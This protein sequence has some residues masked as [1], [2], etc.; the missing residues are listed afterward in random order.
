MM[1]LQRNLMTISCRDSDP[2]PKVADAGRVMEQ[3]P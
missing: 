2:L 3:A 1:P